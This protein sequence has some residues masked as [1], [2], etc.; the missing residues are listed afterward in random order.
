MAATSFGYMATVP[1]DGFRWVR[2]RR[3]PSA[4]ALPVLVPAGLGVYEAERP[5]EV[6]EDGALFLHFAHTNPTQEDILTFA[7]CYGFL[8]HQM[9]L[10]VEGDPSGIIVQGEALWEWQTQIAAMLEAV[11]LW[12][13]CKTGDTDRL[14]RHIVWDKD[15]TRVSFRTKQVK[16]KGIRT[17]WSLIASVE[18]SPVMFKH[19]PPG[20]LI[21]PALAYLRQQ[22]NEQLR[23]HEKGAIPQM[24]WLLDQDSRLQFM[25]STLASAL[26]L[27]LADA[28]ANDRNYARCRVCGTWFEVS[29]GIARSHRRF[30]S[31]ACRVKAYRHRQDMARQMYHKEG[32]TFEEIAEDLDSKVKTVKRWV[33]GD[34]GRP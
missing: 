16:K 8:G 20:D 1:L 12:D 21:L 24:H 32:K 18:T 29:P 4:R 17:K 2:G 31:D 28:V 9:S 34:G 15:Q 26:W 14:G 5:Y 23:R 33:T 25:T 6:S 19:F 22:I 11:N 30:C 7:N 27:Q 3:A 10:E 13:L